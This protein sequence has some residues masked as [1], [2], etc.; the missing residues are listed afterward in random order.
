MAGVRLHTQNFA[1]G[2]AIRRS[3]AS[4]GVAG[5]VD[6]RREP[7][8]ERGGGLGLDREVGDDVLHERLVDEPPAEGRAVGDVPRR[9]GER[10]AHQRRG[11]E[12]AVEPGRGDHLDDRAHAAAL[13]AEPLG[14]GAV[15]LE[16]RGGVGAVAELVLEPHDVDPVAG[17]VV[18]DPRHHEAG[19][20]RRR[21]GRARGRRRSSGPR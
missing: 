2:S 7:Q 21:P 10:R 19:H 12:D 3:A 4:C 9:L 11:A 18:E 6:G 14:Q 20:A 16:L 5:S 1:S 17:A 13:V 15:E 8:R